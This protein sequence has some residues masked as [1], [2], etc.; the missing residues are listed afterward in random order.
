M[1]TAFNPFGVN[2]LMFNFC[3]DYSKAITITMPY[4][5]KEIGWFIAHNV[6][7]SATIYINNISIAQGNWQPSAWSGNLNCQILVSEGDIITGA[8]GIMRFIPCKGKK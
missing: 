6:N 1:H 8:T 4:T 2:D 5:V 3:P 7:T